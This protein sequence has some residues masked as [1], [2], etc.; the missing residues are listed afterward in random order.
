MSNIVIASNDALCQ[1]AKNWFV[2]N[3]KASEG[4]AIDNL[5]D[6]DI[7]YV[8][9][10]DNELGSGEEF[11]QYVSS[12]TGNFPMTK[13]KC[14]L[15]V[16]SA[17]ALPQVGIVSAAENVANYFQRPV[18]ASTT[19]VYGEWDNNGAQFTGEFITVNPGDDI[20]SRFAN[21]TI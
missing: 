16:C 10:H 15:I 4:P 13:W 3:N 2:Q 19:T 7:L 12:S 14:V 6:G 17:A 9:A 18:F 21:M 1:S 8:I 11:T 20:E 5:G